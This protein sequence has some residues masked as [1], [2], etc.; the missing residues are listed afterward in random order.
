MYAGFD[1]APGAP[2]DARRF[3]ST[4]GALVLNCPGCGTKVEDGTTICPSCDYIIDA[5]FISTDAPDESDDAPPPARKPAP[6]PARTA[7]GRPATG[8][9]TSARPAVRTNAGAKPKAASSQ[10]ARPASPPPSD[11]ATNIRS[12]DE[13]VRNASQR[14]NN[15]RP[16]SA[17]RPAAR[18]GGSRPAPPPARP[19]ETQLDPS[20]INYVP[21]RD[22]SGMGTH[23]TGAIMAPEQVVADFRDF[24]GVL[25]LSDKIAFIGALVILLTAFFPWKETAKDGDILG[26]MSTGLIAILGALG[27]LGTIGVR[28]RRFMPNLNV[29][30]PW[31]VQLM[32]SFGCVLWCV[33]F[34]KISYDATEVPSPMG[35]STIMNSSPSMGVFLALLGALACLAGTLL[36]LKEKPAS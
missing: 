34:M 16:A 30:I 25:G 33:I 12:M 23:G 35:N 19:Q 28:V 27:I 26:L 24:M 3:S 5:S 8:R 18:S 22:T 15:A 31:M 13:I 17:P 10:T 9:S 21:T 6:R 14:P 11:D 2:E 20:D 29:L 7:S 32:L 4:Q 36:G 1:L